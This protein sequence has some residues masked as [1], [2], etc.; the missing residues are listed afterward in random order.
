MFKG[1]LDKYIFFI[2]KKPIKNIFKHLMFT[3]IVFLSFF[4]SYHYKI[5]ALWLSSVILF[6]ITYLLLKKVGAIKKFFNIIL[7]KNFSLK[8]K[9][10]LLGLPLFTA[11]SANIFLFNLLTNLSGRTGDWLFYE[12][13]IFQKI[14][15]FYLFNFLIIL[16]VFAL[17][18]KILKILGFKFNSYLELFLFSLA[19]GFIPLMFGTYFI[20]LMGWLYGPVVW[21]MIIGSALISR[22]EI[23]NILSEF[24][25]TELK[26]KLNKSLNFYKNILSKVTKNNTLCLNVAP[27]EKFLDPRVLVKK[28]EIKVNNINWP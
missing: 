25:G 18:R 27:E 12:L 19:V 13:N 20:A 2:N 11:L 3:Y 5:I 9:Y 22:T 26:L 16:L 23:K 28:L 8:L 24:K 4:Y 7:Q 10:F 17:G 15:S 14:F 6:L 21:A 1:L